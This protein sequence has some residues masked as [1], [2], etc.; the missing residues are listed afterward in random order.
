MFRATLITTTVLLSSCLQSSLNAAIVY[1]ESA[2]AELVG[3]RTKAQIDFHTSPVWGQTGTAEEVSWE[4][5][6][7]GNGTF[8]YSYTFAGFDSPGTISHFTLDL[9]DNPESDPAIVTDAK[10]DGVPI[11][12]I[13]ISDDLVDDQF[14]PPGIFSAVK[15]GE[16]ADATSMTYT[17]TSNRSPVYGHFLV[18]GGQSNVATNLALWR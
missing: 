8:D 14:L 13:E 6:N 5:T 16:G 2:M 4:I 17:F 18:K 15:F 1:G 10:L 11:G 12:S 9:S 7:N 3:S